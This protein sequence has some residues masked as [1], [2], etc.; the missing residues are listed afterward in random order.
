ML[1]PDCSHTRR[2]CQVGEEQGAARWAAS[3]M[4]LNRASSADSVFTIISRRPRLAYAYGAL[5]PHITGGIMEL[6]HSKHH[7]TYI[8]ALNAALE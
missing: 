2:K 1:S 8:T 6:H 3:A 4:S 7:Q 5:A